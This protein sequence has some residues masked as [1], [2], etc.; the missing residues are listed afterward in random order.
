M[1]ADATGTSQAMEEQLAEARRLNQQRQEARRT[2][3]EKRIA[4]A[5]A[6]NE[7]HAAALKEQQQRL[8]AQREALA[9]R[10]G[11]VSDGRRARAAAADHCTP[12]HASIRG[13]CSRGSQHSAAHTH[14]RFGGLAQISRFSS[15]M[16]P[17]ASSYSYLTGSNSNSSSSSAG[18]RSRSRGRS[19]ATLRWGGSTRG[20]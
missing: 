17:R 6:Q 16:S 3:E 15:S 1:A 4:R 5:R 20:Y 7:Q 11:S 19:P 18:A 9:K 2:D 10:H 13:S 14:A 12:T 8:Q